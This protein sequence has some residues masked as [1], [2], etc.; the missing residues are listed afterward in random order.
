M[1]HQRSIRAMD[2]S[3]DGNLLM[4]VGGDDHHTIG[5]IYLCLSSLFVVCC[6]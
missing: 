3:P 4:S 2:F 1:F 5:K 6:C